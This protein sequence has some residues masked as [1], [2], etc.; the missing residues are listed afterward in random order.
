MTDN[1]Y[2]DKKFESIKW[3]EKTPILFIH[4]PKC[5]GSSIRKW[6]KNYHP[7]IDNK[8]IVVII[9]GLDNKTSNKKTGDMLQTWILLKDHQ[10]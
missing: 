9:T 2:E 10:L 1:I 7:N 8:D 5:A 3:I 4:I 6:L